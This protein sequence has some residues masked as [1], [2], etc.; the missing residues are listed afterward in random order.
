MC[1][2]CMHAYMCTMCMSDA[3]RIRKELDFVKV[4]IVNCQVG[5]KN[6]TQVL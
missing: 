1:F 2:S 4:D 3:T 5:A 6:C